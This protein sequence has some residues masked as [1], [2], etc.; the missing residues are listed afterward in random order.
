MATRKPIRQINEPGVFIGK[1]KKS[2]YDIIDP[3][4]EI[5][6]AILAIAIYPL[7]MIYRVVSLIFKK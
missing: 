6:I 5:T 4:G 7:V 1:H 3:N 2:L